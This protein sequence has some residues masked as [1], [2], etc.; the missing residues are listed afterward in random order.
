MR[1]AVCGTRIRERPCQLVEIASIAL[2]RNN[3]LS[4]ISLV[5]L[6]LVHRLPLYNF[7]GQILHEYQ[8]ELN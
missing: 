6:C 2:K 4:A 1:K 3:N 7:F 5:W 8:E